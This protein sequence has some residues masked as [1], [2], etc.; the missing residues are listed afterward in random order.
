MKKFSQSRLL[1]LVISFVITMLLSTYIMSTRSNTNGISNGGNNFSNIIPEQR[2]TLKVNLL[3]QYDTDRYVVT[4]APKTVNVKIQGSG[5]L[6]AAAR[7]RNSIQAS[8]D[9]QNL[10]VG[11]HKVVVAIRGVNSDLRSA[12]EPQMITVNVVKKETKKVPVRVTYNSSQIAQGYLVDSIDTT[13]E[14]VTVSGPETNVDAVQSVVGQVTLS[15]NMKGPMSQ[16]VQLQALDK[17]GNAVEVNMSQPSVAA[18]LNISPEDSKKLS[19]RANIQNGEASDY[20]ITFSPSNVTA[21]GASDILDSLDN[22]KISID[23]KNMTQ[24]T[25]QNVTLPTQDGISRYSDQNVK[26]TITPKNTTD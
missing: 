9:L 14:S 25:T 26:V 17:D 20:N 6:V 24:K 13:P 10:G 3:L 21:Y 16:S 15:K 22:L 7:S 18:K 19:L 2:A 11:Q 4:G 5:A 8:A 1:S 12:V 23:V